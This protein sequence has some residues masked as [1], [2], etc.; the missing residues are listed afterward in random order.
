MTTCGTG[1]YDPDL[2]VHS[3]DESM[4]FSK[5]DTYGQEVAQAV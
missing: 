2:S 3:S 1:T 4:N 5:W